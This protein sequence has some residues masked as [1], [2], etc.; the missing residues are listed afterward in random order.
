M[1]LGGLIPFISNR[2]DTFKLQ[3]PTLPW[4]CPIQPGKYSANYTFVFEHNNIAT[5][6]NV[7]HVQQ[8][9]SKLPFVFIAM[10]NGFK[11]MDLDLPNGIYGNIINVTFP[12]D[13][14]GF[15]FNYQYELRQRLGE[16]TF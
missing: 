14:Q 13:T 3:F 7:T 9:K 16:D 5:K 11:I 4:I 6:Q 12:D 15:K 2:I 1:N 8:N 10:E